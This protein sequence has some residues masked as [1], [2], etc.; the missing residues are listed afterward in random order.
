MKKIK[1]FCLLMSEM[2]ISEHCQKLKV[3]EDFGEDL[4]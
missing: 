2:K 3:S 1:I 4:K